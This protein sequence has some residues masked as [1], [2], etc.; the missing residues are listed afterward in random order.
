M[1]FLA[2]VKGNALDALFAC[3]ARDV[4]MLRV[5]SVRDT[6]V[7][8]IVRTS[9]DTLNSWLCEDREPPFPIGSLLHWSPK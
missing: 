2:I 6:D 5:H 9:I 1:T 8:V 4:S 3:E 7:S